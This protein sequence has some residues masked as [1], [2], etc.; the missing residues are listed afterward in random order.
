MQPDPDDSTTDMLQTMPPSR[1]SRLKRGIII[2]LIP[3][4]IVLAVFLLAIIHYTGPTRT[5]QSF[6]KSLLVDANAGATYQQLCSDIRAT[7]SVEQIQ[8]LLN[9]SKAAGYSYDLSGLTYS[10]VDEDFFA[11]A[12]VRLGGVVTEAL[13]GQKHPIPITGNDSIITL[14]SSGLGWCVEMSLL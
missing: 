12:H 6:E 13:N 2:G 5:L 14:R 4:V 7:S 8:L 3:G 10:L 11:V 1:A 9:A